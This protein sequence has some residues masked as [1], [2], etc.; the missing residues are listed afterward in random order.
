[1]YYGV[2]LERTVPSP[3]TFAF[4]WLSGLLL[5]GTPDDDGHAARG[6]W[7]L[8]HPDLRLTAVLRVG[9]GVDE[10]SLAELVKD[11]GIEGKTW[12]RFAPGLVAYLLGREP[13]QTHSL[14]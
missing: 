14:G 11:A 4:S 7:T 3:P 6:T 1:M 13:S 8:S 2:P 10:A 12:E 5:Y 9:A